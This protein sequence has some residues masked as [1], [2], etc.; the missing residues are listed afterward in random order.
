MKT[1]YRIVNKYILIEQLC[2]YSIILIYNLIYII[3]SINS[4]TNNITETVVTSLVI[5]VDV[6]AYLKAPSSTKFKRIS[7]YGFA[8]IYVTLLF[9]SYSDFIYTLGFV[10]AAPYILYFDVVLM[11][12]GCIFM[13]LFNLIAIFYQ[14]MNGH[15]FGGATINYGDISISILSVLVFDFAMI[16]STNTAIKINEEKINAIETEQKKGSTLLEK[17][18]STAKVVKTNAEKANTYM[19]ELNHS[20]ENSLETMNSIANGNTS[21]AESI[22]KQSLMTEHIQMMIESAKEAV[23]V[24]VQNSMD[25]TQ[26]IQDGLT[27]V[28]QLKDKSKNIETFNQEMLQTIQSFAKN[29]EDVKKITEGIQSI[30]SQ[31]NLLALNASIESARAG[32][33]GRGFAV[34]ANEIRILSEQTNNLTNNISKIIAELSQN[35]TNAQNAAKEVVSEMN[36]EHQLI[37][38]TEHQYNEINQQIQ[39]LNQKVIQ[40]QSNVN[41]IYQSN[42]QI[43][44]SITQLS[45]ACEEVTASTEQ[46]VSI[47]E[48]NLIKSNDTMNLMDELLEMATDL[49]NYSIE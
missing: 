19:H 21:N 10:I 3:L 7:L 1:N 28:R 36:Q 30:S 45:A 23:G 48:E 46:S 14:I 8:F 42:N 2:V 43:V 24:M 49:D 16:I 27:S 15:T 29:A 9:F 33:A 5:L 34:V 11:R 44:D 37:E 47:G 26:T 20:T 32:E 22:Q 40:L 13:F 41:E 31:T 25:S 6:V 38:H 4:P 17:V 12:N 18:L 39:E 35:A